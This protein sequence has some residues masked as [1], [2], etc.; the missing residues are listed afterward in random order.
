MQI[1]SSG[2]QPIHSIPGFTGAETAK[3]NKEAG[4]A[5]DS[6]KGLGV[7]VATRLPFS[8]RGVL[9]NLVRTPIRLAQST[10]SG[11]AGMVA[12]GS[13]KAFTSEFST[14]MS[15]HMK[16]DWEGGIQDVG[17]KLSPKDEKAQQIAKD[18]LPYAR[19]VYGNDVGTAKAVLTSKCSEA[20]KPLL[21]NIKSLGFEQ[22]ELTGIFYSKE[23]G[24]C[25]RLMLDETKNELVV[26][27]RGLGH[28]GD[29][30]L[31]QG[32]GLPKSVT[33]EIAAKATSSA[34]SDFFGGVNKA[35]LQVIELGKVVKEAAGKMKGSNEEPYTAKMAGHS[36]GGGLAQTAAAAN[37][38]HGIVFNARP[39]GPG[40]RM[41]IGQSEVAKN[42]EK[43]V[44]FS[45]EG[46]Y[47]SACTSLNVLAKITERLTGFVLPR[48]VGK[49]YHLPP[50]KED[51]AT[52]QNL[53]NG[54]QTEFSYIDH[55]LH[56]HCSFVEQLE[57][58]A[59]GPPKAMTEEEFNRLN[60][61]LK[62]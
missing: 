41:H 56:Q 50:A 58:V 25:F 38:L 53:T 3:V 46:D 31:E 2:M 49:E 30:S 51:R 5:V 34:K 52:V 39:M 9:L 47:L 28:E 22:D 12:K 54:R 29:M 55:R 61:H 42:S 27:F 1:H 6:L 18:N 16:S 60:P 13:A 19:M 26:C 33:K 40:V 48:T 35:A 21:D 7:S 59:K 44:A 20:M 23:T 32:G 4:G 11:I 14:K 24:T 10:F 17:T 15:A 36:H 62:M 57:E 37:G 45:G 8:T 43:I